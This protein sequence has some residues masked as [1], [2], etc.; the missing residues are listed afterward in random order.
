VA[1]VERRETGAQGP[2]GLARL[3]DLPDGTQ[4]LREIIDKA[5][6]FLIHSGKYMDG[7]ELYRRAAARFPRVAV[8]HQGIGCCAGHLGRHDDAITASRAALALEPDNPKLVIDLGWSL[9]EAERL[10]EAA[11]R[12]RMCRRDGPERCAGQGEPAHLPERQRRTWLA[13]APPPATGALT[14]PEGADRTRGENRGVAH[15]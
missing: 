11:P 7:L 6:D 12:T 14:N 4:D 10:D 3:L 2:Q 1:G 5:G 15:G 8:F 9:Y 13:K